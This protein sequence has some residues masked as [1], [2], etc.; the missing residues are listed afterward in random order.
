M[1]SPTPGRLSILG[2]REQRE[3]RQ[4]RR[5]FAWRR[6]HGKACGETSRPGGVGAPPGH[7]PAA[8]MRLAG[9]GGDGAI[10]LTWCLEPCSFADLKRRDCDLGRREWSPAVVPK[11][12]GDGPVRMLL[13]S[14]TRIGALDHAVRAAQVFPERADL[15]GNAEWERHKQASRYFRHVWELAG[16]ALSIPFG[17]SSV[18]CA[19]IWF[20]SSWADRRRRGSASDSAC[21]TQRG[22]LSW[23]STPCTSPRDGRTFRKPAS[24]HSA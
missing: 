11:E 13:E 18:R 6:I 8:M 21:S 24:S 3:P 14:L 12:L 4:A 5:A 10:D 15:Y 1:R 23:L 22:R 17:S 2:C 20:A 7:A 16:C 19:L 9:N